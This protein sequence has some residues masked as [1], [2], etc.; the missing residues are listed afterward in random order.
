VSAI[1][2]LALSINLEAEALELVEDAVN[3]ACQ[4]ILGRLE[5]DMWRSSSKNFSVLYLVLFF[6]SPYHR[7]LVNNV[8][9]TVFLVSLKAGGVVLNLTEASR[10][11][12]TSSMQLAP[13]GR[14]STPG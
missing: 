10:V 11:Y 3:K 8:D 1:L 13:G 9:V 7:S 6:P 2:C 5:L 14:L 12:L 4:G